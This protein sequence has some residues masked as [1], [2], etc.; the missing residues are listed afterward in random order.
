MLNVRKQKQMQAEE[1]E[2][3]EYNRFN[4]YQ[5]EVKPSSRTSPW[6]SCNP[7]TDLCDNETYTHT[8]RSHQ[9]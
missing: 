1:P 9:A 5:R 8:A 4:G 7:Q 3:V 6:S 2:D